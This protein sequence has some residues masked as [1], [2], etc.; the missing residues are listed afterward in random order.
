VVSQVP[1]ADMLRFH[2]FTLGR[3]WIAEYGNADLAE[4]FPFL[5]KYSPYHN[6]KEGTDYPATLITTADTDDRV[7]PSHAKKLAAR[8]QAA[9][10]GS[11]PILLRIETKA[12][13]GAGKPISKQIDLA[14]DIWTFVFWQLGMLN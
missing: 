1:V 4:D 12:G 9:T 3:Y 14:A 5:F 11:D 13:H 8:I 10:S 2:K 6:V 7:D